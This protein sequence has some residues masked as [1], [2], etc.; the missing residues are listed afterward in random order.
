MNHHS[1]SYKLEE[2]EFGGEECYRL[3][4]DHGVLITFDEVRGWSG[5]FTL[6]RNGDQKAN[7][8]K[9]ILPTQVK[10]EL[11]KIKEEE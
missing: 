7:V 8:D 1:T 10:K 9:V 11:Q 6:H 2:G 3:E 5:T 4:I